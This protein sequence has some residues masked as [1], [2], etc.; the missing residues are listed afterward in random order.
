M[1]PEFKFLN[2]KNEIETKFKSYFEAITMHH[3]ETKPEPSLIFQSKPFFVG[4]GFSIRSESRSGSWNGSDR[5]W[6][7]KPR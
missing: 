1:K 6:E 7:K 3:I 5:N 2:Y 4:T